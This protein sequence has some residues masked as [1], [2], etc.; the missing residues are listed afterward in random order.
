MA[1]TMN[2]DIDDKTMDEFDALC[3][4]IGMNVETAIGIFVKQTRTAET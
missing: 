3:E 2:L 4:K 1:R